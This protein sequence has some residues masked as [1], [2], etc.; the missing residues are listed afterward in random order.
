MNIFE[1]IAE[2]RIREAMQNGEFE[3]L[4]GKGRPIDLKDYFNLPG[5]LRAAYG[6]LRNANVLPSEIQLMKEIE[7]LQNRL[8]GEKDTRQ[9]KT[10]FR[11]I[12]IRQIEL[13]IVMEKLRKTGKRG[14]K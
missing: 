12:Q 2:V 3:N 1:K 13:S 9:R 6:L 4:P 8:D 7:Q 11:Q 10:I 5:H 14:G